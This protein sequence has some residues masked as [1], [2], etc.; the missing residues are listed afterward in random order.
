MKLLLATTA[1]LTLLVT[2]S[3]QTDPFEGTWTL[4]I[5]KSRL[6]RPLKAATM[7]LR[8]GVDEE[9]FQRTAEQLS[10]ETVTVDGV[11]DGITYTA[12]YSGR[13]GGDYWIF[14][15]VTGEGTGEEAVVRR[16]DENTRE[17]RRLRA[18]PGDRLRAHERKVVE[19]TRRTLSADGQTTMTAEVVFAEADGSPVKEVWIWD[20]Q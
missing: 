7:T 18:V 15:L 16:I 12:L 20:K 6:S 2:V 4:N 11:R 9:N 17:F 8:I 1:F 14:D 13:P 3:A 5:E 19:T 10:L